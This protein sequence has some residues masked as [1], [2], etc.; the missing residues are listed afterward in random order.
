MPVAFAATICLAYAPYLSVGAKAALGFLPGYAEQEGL[1]SGDRFFL[2]S[3]ARRV[4]PGGVPGSVYI[5][6]AFGLL[7]FLAAWSL[8]RAER[9]DAGFLTASCILATAFT[10][11]LSPHYSWYFSW[12]VPLM[13]F[14]PAAELFYLTAAS[15]VLYGTWLGDAPEQLFRLNAALYLPFGLL[16]VISVAVRYA[17]RWTSQSRR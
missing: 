17:A 11:L 13:C 2:L 3:L 4:I 16:A 6:L 5:I 8:R 14:V 9:S 1:E 10:V 12:L 7:C 15:F